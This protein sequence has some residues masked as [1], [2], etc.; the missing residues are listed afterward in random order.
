MVHSFHPFE[1]YAIKVGERIKKISDPSIEV[2]GFTPKSIG[3][4]FL[5]LLFDENYTEMIKRNWRGATE[6]RNHIKSL[7]EKYDFVIV[8]HST[9]VSADPCQYTIFYPA[10]NFR[11]E[12]V[13]KY[14]ETYC[15][16]NGIDLVGI[17][18]SPANYVGNHSSIIDFSVKTPS[19][20]GYVRRLRE[21]E[22]VSL[23]LDFIK[24]IK[25]HYI[26]KS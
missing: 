1:K 18:D 8:L 17:G 6:L 5:K 20:D 15:N 12:K 24:W 3:D 2:I 21:E 10:L 22:G 11:L 26:K 13:I 4:D 14:F 7:Y 16:E 25:T 19:K 9:P 23:T